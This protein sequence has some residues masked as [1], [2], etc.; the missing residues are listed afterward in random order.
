MLEAL[1]EKTVTT[2]IRLYLE[3]AA[4]LVLLAAF[5]LY[6]WHERTVGAEHIS[7]ADAKAQSAAQKQADAET[8]LNLAK[9][10]KADEVA[11]SAQKAVD[12]YVA[13]QP[14]EPVRLC[15]N[16]RLPIPGQGS[17]PNP[18]AQSTGAGPNALPKVQSGTVGADIGPGFTEIVLSAARVAVLYNDL[19]QR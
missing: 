11:A 12:T 10:A 14:I 7:Q 3:I 8:Q 17:R 5:G 18:T 1:R 19:Q 6:T 9:A 13:S 16:S 4:V 2:Q 15:S